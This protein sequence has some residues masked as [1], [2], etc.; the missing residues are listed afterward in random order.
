ML[1]PL[2]LEVDDS[3]GWA[4]EIGLDYDLGNDWLISGRLWYMRLETAAKLKGDTRFDLD[5]NPWV[6]MIDAGKKP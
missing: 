2:D 3:W 6:V 1:K 4:G 5:I